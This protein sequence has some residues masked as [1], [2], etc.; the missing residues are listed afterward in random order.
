MSITNNEQKPN[1]NIFGANEGIWEYRTFDSEL[2]GYSVRKKKG[3]GK[4]FEPWTFQEGKWI[5]KWHDSPT[6]PVYNCPDLKAHPQK[7]VL[8]VEGE[9]TADAAALMFPDYVVITWLGGSSSAQKIDTQH[10]AGRTIYIWPDNDAP[11][12]KAQASLHKVLSPIAANVYC[13]NVETL[14]VGKG[15]DL[16]DFEHEHG[17]IDFD[18]IL[19]AMND[20]RNSIKE[21]GDFPMLSANN[22]PLNMPEN[23]EHIAQHY[24]ISLRFNIITKKV[25]AKIPHSNFSITN[26][27]RLTVVEF[28]RLAAMHGIPRTNVDS[29]LLWIAD[30]HRYNPVKEWIKS[31]PWD[32]IKRFHDFAETIEST[33]NNLKN[34]LLRRWMIGAVAVAYIEEGGVPHGVLTFVGKTGVGKSSWIKKLVPQE[35][36]LMLCDYDFDPFN[37]DH[38]IEITSSWLSE[39]GEAGGTHKSTNIDALKNFIIKLYDYYRVPYGR[40]VTEAPRN[41]AFLASLNNDKFLRDLTGNRR[42]WTINAL[43]MDYEHSFDMQQVWAEIENYYLNGEQYHLA[44][45]EMAALNSSNEDFMMIQPLEERLLTSYDM[46]SKG[47][48]YI[49]CTE[50]LME[51]GYDKPTESETRKL[52]AVLSKMEVQKGKGRQ[53]RSYLM[54][55][56][57]FF[58][59]RM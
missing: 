48:R 45:E 46:E 28:E 26:K 27:D 43:K 49:T 20:S 18:M 16:A 8:V 23:F 7:L 5:N 25:D 30:R 59:G 35:L 44:Q 41:T 52:A 55:E 31:K 42:W 2:L 32:G 51:L 36:K 57:T 58:N 39:M 11:G 22:K 29:W 38:R 54:P 1:F 12:L 24:G 14:G 37:K 17:E 40:A 21:I 3:V 34:I 6:K 4:R 56:C 53:R 19:M 50:I 13:I 9:K 10:L 47:T 15:W 33:D